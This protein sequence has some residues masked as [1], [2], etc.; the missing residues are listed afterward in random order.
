MAMTIFAEVGYERS[1]KY[2]N[3]SLQY[4]DSNSKEFSDIKTCLFYQYFKAAALNGKIFIST[5]KGELII[6]RYLAI[7]IGASSGR[8]I[9]GWRENGILKTQEVYRFINGPK[10]ADGHLIWDL[11]YLCQE[12][13]NGLKAAK[14]AGYEPDT[15][16]IDTWAVDYVLLDHDDK[17]ILPL[18]CYRDKR[19]KEA[20]EKVHALLPFPELYA[21][22]GIQYQPFNTIY[23]MTADRLSGR[24]AQ[25]HDF[26]M[27][28]EY[29]SFY[30]SGVKRHD[31]TDASSTALLNAYRKTWDKSII[32]ALGFP[33]K[34]F[35]REPEMPPLLLG[36]LKE[37]IAQAVGFNC[38]VILPATHD[39]ASAI[40][41]LTQSKGEIAYLSSGTWSL[42]GTELSEP[43]INDAARR[44]NYTNEGGIKTIRFLK[45]IMG[46]WLIQCLRREYKDQYSF[47]ELA[48]KAQKAADFPYHLAVNAP[49]YLAP[50]SIRTV[51]DNECS[52]KGYPLPKTVGEYAA[53]IYQSLAYAYAEALKELE[54]LTQ[55]HYPALWIVGGGGKNKYLNKLT[56]EA[57]KRPVI[58]GETEATAIGNILLQ[59]KMMNTKE[60][61]H[62]YAS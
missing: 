37:E 50:V 32:E 59:E 26:L 51:I 17:A 60:N 22:T 23:Q 8:H 21:K 36:K 2:F 19:G 16:G 1:I 55:K 6:M 46:L 57:I 45:N 33:K 54:E 56:A 24:L 41:S 29:L 39:T 47:A 28:P 58:I 44:A 9:V 20:A 4:T 52:A 30:L 11:P 25:A 10:E 7:D 61:D 48:E 18:Y 35:T 3:L 49:S 14:E 31:Y 43:L 27:L 38:Q 34:L 12:V 62:V 42:L 15:L 53:A 5:F 13:I 40:A